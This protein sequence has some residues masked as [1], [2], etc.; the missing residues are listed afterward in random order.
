VNSTSPS[1]SS[2]CFLEMDGETAHDVDDHDDD[3]Q[4]R[5]HTLRARHNFWRGA[6]LDWPRGV[7]NLS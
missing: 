5:P 6:D 3:D 1:T 7:Q 4:H 2:P